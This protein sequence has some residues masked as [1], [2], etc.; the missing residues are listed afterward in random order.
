MLCSSWSPTLRLL[1]TVGPLPKRVPWQICSES[2]QRLEFPAPSD[3]TAG[4]RTPLVWSV[5]DPYS[6]R[7]GSQSGAC[8][9]GACLLA[10]VGP[11]F[12]R[13]GRRICCFPCLSHEALKAAGPLASWLVVHIYLLVFWTYPL[14]LPL[15][16]LERWSVGFGFCCL[17]VL[18]S[19]GAFEISIY[20]TATATVIF[21]ELSSVFWWFSRYFLKVWITPVSLLCPFVVT[22]PP[23]FGPFLPTNHWSLPSLWFCVF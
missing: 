5:R 17:I 1:S 11:S 7:R 3:L 2:S 18:S 9:S 14:N 8:T 19:C 22:F 21:P 10:A 15:S 6:V 4:L 13:S 16:L 20:Y 23:L 12:V